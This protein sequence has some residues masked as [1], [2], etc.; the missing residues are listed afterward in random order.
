MRPFYVIV[1]ALALS[2]C[3]SKSTPKPPDTKP[4]E[5]AKGKPEGLIVLDEA[6]QQKA[7]LVIA[8]IQ[9]RNAAETITAPGQ[10]TINEDRT[11]HVGTIA[12][13]KVDTVL[14]RVGDFVRAGQVLARIHSHDVH[15]ARAAYR[16]A[17]VEL[18]RAQ[19]G[20]A[21][22]LRLRDRAQRLFDL[23]AGSRQEVESAEAELR[24]ARA[25][26]AKAQAELEK[27]KVH[28]TDILR[29]PLN[30]SGGHG[31]EG[32]PISAPAAGV[33]LARKATVGSVVNAGDELFTL[34]D[35]S[36]LWMIAAVSELD[37]SKLNSGQPVRLLVRA[38]PHQE[39]SGRILKLGE[40]LDPATRTL[41]V[42]I[43]VPNPRGLLKPEMFATAVLEQPGRRPSLFVPEAAVQ[44][45]S[46]IPAVFVRRTADQFEPRP[47][48]TGR[49]ANGETEVIEGLRGGE[50][51]VVKGGFMLKSQMLKSALAEE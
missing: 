45:I 42:R 50:R 3:N 25:Q 40:Q 5:S 29:V 38:Y 9:A 46:G 18:A 10:L 19:S 31:E 51:V 15:E 24:N 28:V 26:V 23:K 41:Q 48:K 27:E 8:T 21:Y 36:T 6:A 22:A 1:A 43:Q 30:D 17:S 37:L 49:R 12:D 34:A 2:S 32:I 11:W 47:V 35:L 16:E 14:A 44:E 20:E 13:G 4:A 7:H 33:V 39:F